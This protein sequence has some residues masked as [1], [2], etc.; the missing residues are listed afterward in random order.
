MLRRTLALALVSAIAALAAVQVAAGADSVGPAGVST[1]KAPF[2]QQFIDQMAAHH[3]MAIEMAKMALGSAKHAQL[4]AMARG[5]ISAQQKEIA[6]FH[7]LRKQWY[8]SATFT[9]Y[10]MDAMMTQQMG[11][12]GMEK[13]HA[14]MMSPAAFDRAF[15]DGMIPHHAGAITMANWQLQSGTHAALKTIAAN[16]IRAQSKEIGELIAL[17]KSW[18]GS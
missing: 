17:R 12:G 11:M 18:Y 13:L 16:I 5:I 14:A 15:I 6:A 7:K 3:E 10:P 1:Q 8:G 4:K 2:D 9:A